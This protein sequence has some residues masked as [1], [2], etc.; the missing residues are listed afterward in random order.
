MSD[1]ETKIYNKK[2]S[3]AESCCA[4]NCVVQST[5]SPYY[6]LNIGS[7]IDDIFNFKAFK[8]ARIP[9]DAK[10]VMNVSNNEIRLVVPGK[11]ENCYILPAIKDIQIIQDKVVVVLFEDGTKE[12]AVLDSEDTF[13]LEQGVSI[14]ITKKLLSD[15]TDGNGSS[16][17][18]KIITHCCK[19]YENNRK[20]EEKAKAEQQ[21]AKEKEQR[22][23][24]KAKR[25][26]IKKANKMRERE[27]EIQK[28]AYLRAMREFNSAQN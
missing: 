1:S 24:E 19:L 23:I 15:K 2:V 3:A 7:P 16:A 25:K 10:T 11:R 21:A 8:L 4:T 17:Y 22:A 6:Y 9:K 20:A 27:I 18:N 5:S 28:E 12:K 14:C 13:S 26:R